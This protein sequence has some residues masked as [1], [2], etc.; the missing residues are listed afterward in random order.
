MGPLPRSSGPGKHF[1]TT[2]LYVSLVSTGSHAFF[3]QLLGRRG[4]DWLRPI[5]T[6]SPALRAQPDATQTHG[7]SLGEELRLHLSFWGS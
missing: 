3:R 1:P 6:P 4:C 7:E 5:K 2:T